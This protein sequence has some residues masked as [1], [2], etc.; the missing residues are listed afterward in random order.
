[1]IAVQILALPALEL[2]GLSKILQWIFLL[3]FP[4]Y[5][6]G[7][8]LID[9]YNNFQITKICT[10][11]QF[12]QICASFPNP[13][14][15]HFSDNPKRCGTNSTDDCF[16][17]NDNYMAWEKP[18]LARFY[19][20]M[21]LQFLIQ[22]GLLL[23]YDAGYFRLINYKI[24][25]ILG[26]GQKNLES[27]NVDQLALE[28]QFGD[29]QKDS[30]VIDEE[31]RIYNFVNSNAFKNNN[32]ETNEIFIVDRLTKYF[33]NFMAVKGISFSVKKAESFGLL[34]VN[35]AGKTTTFKM[36]TGDEII[37]KGD[38]FLNKINIKDDIKQFQRQLGYCPQF[39]P[40]I[41]Q[42]TV[43]ETMEMYANLRGIKP[44]LIKK[45]CLSL[46]SLLD[47]NDHVN[48]M[49]YTLSGGNKRKL[50]VAIALVGSPIIILLDEPT[51]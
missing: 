2:V 5:S 31:K 39:D 22:F 46:I 4:N 32:N 17:W 13:C 20:F 50:S 35:G 49:C 51:S 26:I 11:T 44:N 14:C 27:L 24:Q 7:Q 37:T 40:L 3:I 30:D 21:P 23:I 43:Y 36:I 41:D 28:E 9:M 16:L 1:L 18:G 12:D 38:A 42:M 10:E 25:N 47:L 29:I 15:I 8:A 19:V 6:F 33:S 34:G 45:T 48:K